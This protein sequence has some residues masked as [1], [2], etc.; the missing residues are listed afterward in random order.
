MK[1]PIKSF[2]SFKDFPQENNNNYRTSSDIKH[3]LSSSLSKPI[4]PTMKRSSSNSLYEKEDRD[5][6]FNRLYE[7]AAKK[8]IFLQKVQNQEKDKELE[9]CTFR[10]EITD[11]GQK[12]GSVYE[13]LN[14]I[15]NKEKEEFYKIQKESKELEGC[16]FRPKINSKSASIDVSFEKLYKDAE[17]Q[18]QKQRVKEMVEKKKEMTD[19]T[20]RPT[21]LNPTVSSS[22][23]V[24]EKLYNSYQESQKERRRLELERKNKED[25]EVK[26]IP[27]LLTPKKEGDNT[28]VYA[29]LY[30]E[31]E[32]RREKLKKNN[33]ERERSNSA[34]RAKKME[35]PPRYEHLYSMHKE[36]QERKMVLQEKYFKESGVSFKPD[37]NKNNTPKKSNPK[38]QYPL[39]KKPS[40]DN[41]S[42][43]SINNLEKD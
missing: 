28:P 16:T 22:G 42:E 5:S 35:D 14:S 24:Y 36:T 4:I 18:R 41:F 20:F 39:P 15:D 11:Y 21:V 40:I 2:N 38:I 9:E 29:R 17:V 6:F 13:R 12:K 33:E 19:C 26:F 8:K 3:L 34:P 1:S 32:K 43:S 37:L 23:S 10:P 25:E 7:D 30:A 31:V 27:K